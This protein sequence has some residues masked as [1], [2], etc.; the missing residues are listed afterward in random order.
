VGLEV[1]SRDG[2]RLGK[3]KN[4]VGDGESA[5]EY[6]V[7]G[8]FLAR[9]LVIPADTV[10]VPGDHVVVPHG[11]SFID[12]APSVKAKGAI[13]PAD[14]ARLEDFFRSPAA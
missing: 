14:A 4:I 9:D 1:F 5:A 3:I 8:R 13:S 11:S 12:S 7:I 6:L 2:A 10:E